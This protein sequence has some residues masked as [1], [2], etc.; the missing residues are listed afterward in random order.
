M[1]P[2]VGRLGRVYAATK[3]SIRPALSLESVTFAECGENM[4][5]LAEYN[6]TKCQVCL[7]AIINLQKED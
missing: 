6:Y 1:A 4:E 3:S 2:R 7:P 5:T